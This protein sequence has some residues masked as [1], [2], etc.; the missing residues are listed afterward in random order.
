MGWTRKPER[1]SSTFSILTVAA[2]PL[3]AKI[4]NDKKRMP[5]LLSG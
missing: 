2:N 1:Q 4:H 3:M 5:V